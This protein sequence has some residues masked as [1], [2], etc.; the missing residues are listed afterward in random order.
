MGH[1]SFWERTGAASSRD[2][3]Q[4][5]ELG[6]SRWQQLCGCWRVTGQPEVIT[7]LL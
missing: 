4:T 2:V 3:T 5:R 1:G 6:C 7:G